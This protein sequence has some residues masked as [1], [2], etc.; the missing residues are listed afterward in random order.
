MQPV[1]PMNFSFS[2][3]ID[4]CYLK[5]KSLP[6]K[7]KKVFQVTQNRTKKLVDHRKNEIF[8]RDPSVARFRQKLELDFSLIVPGSGGVLQQLLARRW[9][10]STRQR[11]RLRVGRRLPVRV[12]GHRQILPAISHRDGMPAAREVKQSQVWKEKSWYP[13]SGKRRPDIKT[14]RHRD[15]ISCPGAARGRLFLMELFPVLPRW[16]FW[17]ENLVGVGGALH[18]LVAPISVSVQHVQRPLHL[19][20]EQKG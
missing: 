16:S 9:F 5:K 6:L 8:D 20:Q 7:T 13:A 1:V 3:Y 12:L 10:L 4:E 18:R 11:R 17:T 15:F 19:H 14:F 2:N